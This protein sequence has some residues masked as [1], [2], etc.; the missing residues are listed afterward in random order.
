MAWQHYLILIGDLALLQVQGLQGCW[1]VSKLC[2]HITPQLEM[3]QYWQA[4]DLR[5]IILSLALEG[6]RAGQHLCLLPQQCLSAA[7]YGVDAHALYIKNVAC[8]TS[9]CGIW[10]NAR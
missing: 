8:T 6:K 10:Q 2:Q 9:A 1:Q 3:L 5:Y 7:T 4:P